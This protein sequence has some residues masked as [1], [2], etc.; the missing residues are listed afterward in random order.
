MEI[1]ASSRGY[2]PQDGWL[3][4]PI[5]AAH[6]SIIC[7]FGSHVFIDGIQVAK[8]KSTGK[9]HSVLLVWKDCIVL[10]STQYFMLGRHH[11]SF[12]SRYFGPVEKSQ[13]VGTAF[14]LSGLLK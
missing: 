12:D 5:Y 7:R 10:S 3:L 4:K 11:Y 14:A 13:V 9:M 6:P 2:L 8:A 1:Y